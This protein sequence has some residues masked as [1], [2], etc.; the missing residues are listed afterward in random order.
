MPHLI[1]S[2]G[3]VEEAGGGRRW[4]ATTQT[5]HS[6]RTLVSTISGLFRVHLPRVGSSL[7]LGA[8]LPLWHVGIVRRQAPGTAAT[9]DVEDGIE[10]LAQGVYPGA[11]RSFRGR[12]MGLYV[13]P[14]GIGEVG[15]ICFSHARYSTELPSQDT[16][17]DSFSRVGFSH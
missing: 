17:S 4:Q 16:L 10:D 7:V 9:H 1:N 5:C 6:G 15:L 12:E 3:D 2:Q 11:S 8:H 13:E 14:L